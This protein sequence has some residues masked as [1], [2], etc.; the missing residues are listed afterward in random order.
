ME[1]LI[2]AVLLGLIPAAIA[3]SKGHNF[4]VWWLYG[5]AIWIVAIVHAVL[6]KQDQRELEERAV[7]QGDSRKCPHC[8]EIIKAE[9]KVC[10][11]CGRDVEPAVFRQPVEKAP[12]WYS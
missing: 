1:I 5:A 4:F 7:S 10:R 9:A 8:A 11:F 3:H 2:F 12:D 6:L